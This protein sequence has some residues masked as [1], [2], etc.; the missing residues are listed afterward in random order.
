MAIQQTPKAEEFRHQLRSSLQHETLSSRAIKI[1]R[2]DNV[3]TS[4]DQDEMVYFIESGQIKLLML[5]ADG[6]ECLL[7]IHSDGDIFGELCLSGLGARL[8]TA[9]AMKATILKQIPCSQFFARLSRDALFEGFVR[10]LAVRIADQQQ[11]IANLV[12]VDSEQRLGQTLLRL[13][14]T[15]GKKDPRSIRIELRISHEELSEM[16]GTT[17]PRVSLFMQ[18]FHN[19]GLIETNKDRFLIIKEKKLADYLAQIA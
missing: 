10:Y 4:G 3:Y 7:A 11:V 5:S 6:K 13:A 2:H 12:T 18:R 8:E 17:R 19:L 1:A 16:V 9:T 15:M 14:R